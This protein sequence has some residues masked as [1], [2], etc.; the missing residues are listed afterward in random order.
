MSKA[1]REAYV[2]VGGL[3]CVQRAAVAGVECIFRVAHGLLVLLALLALDEDKDADDESDK[4]HDG[5]GDGC[6]FGSFAHDG[7]LLVMLPTDSRTLPIKL[8]LSR[9]KGST[10]E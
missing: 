7:F 2:Y 5:Q 9:Y 4:A 10:R 6:R 1:G 8:R 3:G